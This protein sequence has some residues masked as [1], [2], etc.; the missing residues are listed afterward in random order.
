MTHPT[1]G[2]TPP[3]KGQTKAALL[4]ELRGL[5]R[6]EGFAPPDATVSDRVTPEGDKK[7]RQRCARSLLQR[8]FG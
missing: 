2:Y 7:E 4:G 5:V 3:S 1:R 6:A 8:D